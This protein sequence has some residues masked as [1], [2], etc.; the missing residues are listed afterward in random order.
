[1]VHSQKKARRLAKYKR[2][3]EKW[4][5]NEEYQKQQKLRLEKLKSRPGYEKNIQRGKEEKEERKR[6]KRAN[7]RRLEIL[8]R[9][10]RRK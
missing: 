2:K 6:E 3:R 5:F 7:F 4:F 10:T 8:K 1:M 9:T